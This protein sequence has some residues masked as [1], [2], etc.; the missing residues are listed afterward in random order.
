MKKS[1]DLAAEAKADTVAYEK[2]FADG[3]KKGWQQGWEKG[4]AEGFRVWAEAAAANEKA[5]KT[6]A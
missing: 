2:G 6:K 5:A 3:F 4:T 1:K